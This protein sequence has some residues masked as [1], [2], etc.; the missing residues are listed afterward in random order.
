M[1][2]I[3]LK[4]N[5]HK[6]VDRIQSEQLLQTLYD[7]LKSREKS[8]T[9]RLWDTLTEEQKQEVILGYEESEDENDLLDRDQVFK[10]K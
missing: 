1:R 10:S 6:I 4:S 3:E 9:N 2:T 7:F 5:I 8:K